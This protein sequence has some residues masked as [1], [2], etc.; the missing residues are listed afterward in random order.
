[1]NILEQLVRVLTNAYSRSQRVFGENVSPDPANQRSFR[2]L[3]CYWGQLLI[4]PHPLIHLTDYALSLSLSACFL[5][6][7]FMLSFAKD[8]RQL[9]TPRPYSLCPKVSNTNGKLLSPNHLRSLPAAP[10]SDLSAR[11]YKGVI[12]GYDVR[13]SAQQHV[14]RGCYRSY[15]ATASLWHFQKK[16]SKVY[17]GDCNS[18]F[19]FNKK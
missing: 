2:G 12:P 16:N 15:S 4:N 14:F 6:T 11:Q 19:C 13:K 1:M 10:H 7:C 18:Y 5:R 9:Q 3:P 17:Y 8:K